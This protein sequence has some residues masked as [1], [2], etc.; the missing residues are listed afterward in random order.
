MYV[1]DKERTREIGIKR[2]VGA[3]K[4]TIVFQFIFESL[5]IAFV[6]GTFGILISLGLIKLIWMIPLSEG[7]TEYLARPLLSGSIVMLAIGILTLIGLLAGFFPARKAA[8]VD[9]V[10][11]LRY[12]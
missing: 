5:L 11:A 2:A 7:A 10:G 4:R 8:S 6:V 3:K 9:P 12:E 1:L